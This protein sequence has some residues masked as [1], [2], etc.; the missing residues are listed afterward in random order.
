MEVIHPG[1]TKWSPLKATVADG[2]IELKVPL[3]RGCAMVK[4]YAAEK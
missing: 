2:E 1:Q 3:E 4:L